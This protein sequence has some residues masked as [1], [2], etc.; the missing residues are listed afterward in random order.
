MTWIEALRHCL[1]TEPASWKRENR[2][3]MSPVVYDRHGEQH[4][5]KFGNLG[6]SARGKIISKQPML[7]SGSCDGPFDASLEPYTTTPPAA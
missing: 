4:W 1:A 7:C 6:Y 5:V 2:M 3:K